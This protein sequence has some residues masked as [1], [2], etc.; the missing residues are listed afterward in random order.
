MTTWQP[1]HAAA[2]AAAAAATSGGAIAAADADSAAGR[3]A[4]SISLVK[5]I[6]SSNPVAAT[7]DALHLDRASVNLF[8][9]GQTTISRFGWNRVLRISYT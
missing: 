2:A 3:A 7:S 9:S 6:S 5:H 1:L 4:L 8:T